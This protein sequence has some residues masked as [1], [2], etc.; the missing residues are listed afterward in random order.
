MKW[1]KLYLVAFLLI[2]FFGL[3]CDVPTDLIPE[4]G[5]W[6]RLTNDARPNYDPHFTP[7]GPGFGY[8]L[9][10]QGNDR[11]AFAV[12]DLATETETQHFTVDPDLFDTRHFCWWPTGDSVVTAVHLSETEHALARIYLD[13]SYELL[14]PVLADEVDLPTV[15]P[16]GNRV[17]FQRTTACM[18]EDIACFL[19]EYNLVTGEFTDLI[20][21]KTLPD[22]TG[23]DYVLFDPAGEWV[24]FIET[25]PKGS[26]TMQVL[27]AIYWPGE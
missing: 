12:F 4:V 21:P 11:D 7:H 16:L 9:N 23:Y 3:D 18:E 6:M 8:W 1:V 17:V 14:T 13:G 25:Y 26:V 2:G 22:D 24:A 15:D 5:D 19:C 10:L 27:K 20:R